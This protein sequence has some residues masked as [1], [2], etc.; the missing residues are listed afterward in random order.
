M[1]DPSL[2]TD[3]QNTLFCMLASTLFDRSFTPSEDTDW[4]DV[5]REAN[6]QT[7]I[8][9][10]FYNARGS[11]IP[12]DHMAEI[13]KILRGGVMRDM[14]IHNAYSYPHDPK[15]DPLRDAQGGCLGLL[16]SSN[17]PAEH[18]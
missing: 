7:V 3:T 1:S 15:R 10:V 14:L 4:M 8:P 2:F 16:L 5:L 9:T 17:L 13:K 12:E 6:A 11:F 18:G